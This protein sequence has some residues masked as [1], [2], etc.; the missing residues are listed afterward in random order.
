MLKTHREA[1]A[2]VTI[3]ALP[4]DEKKAGAFGIMRVNDSFRVE[5]FLE[6]PKTSKELDLV[7]TSPDWIDA[8]GIKSEGRT[9]L[10]SMGI[11]LFNRDTLVDML[12]KTDYQD[13][14][15]EVFPAAIRARKVQLHLFDGYWEDIGTID[16]FYEANLLLAAP[17]PPFR[18]DLPGAPVYTHARFLPPTR[19]DG[20]SIIGSLVADGCRIEHGA[21]VK[22]SMI[23]LRCHIGPDAT[24]QD[25]VLM[26]ADGYEGGGGTGD[27]PAVGIGRGAVIEHAIVDK[28]CRIGNSV[29]LRKPKDFPEN[30]QSGPVV[31][32]DG[33]IVVPKGTVLPDGWSF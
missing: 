33:V 10:A 22:N 16:A 26:G 12:E 18:L 13:F 2:D 20:A 27:F 8:R 25:S 29:T 11:Y 19:I 23:G 30:G 5:G 3:A 32:R 21:V 14:G 1:G 6:K 17:D 9:C 28:N 31:V 15:K 4:V 24:I 7:R